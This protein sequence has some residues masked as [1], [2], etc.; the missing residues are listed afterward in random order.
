[1]T[2]FSTKANI[3]FIILYRY[4]GWSFGLPLT[5]DL[6]FDVT[7][8]PANR[9]LAKVNYVL[10]SGMSHTSECELEIFKH[11]HEVKTKHGDHQFEKQFGI[12]H[13]LKHSNSSPVYFTQGNVYA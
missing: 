6:R 13:T 10:S 2:I 11:F 1:M 12:I 3:I 9:T 5:D 4:G 8:V 7:E